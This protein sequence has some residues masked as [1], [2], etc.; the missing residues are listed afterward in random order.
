MLHNPTYGAEDCP[1][2]PRTRS[3]LDNV[4]PTDLYE[5]ISEVQQ[6]N[7]TDT[8]VTSCY[9][10]VVPELH[11]IPSE[12]EC[13]VEC[14]PTSST[15]V[16]PDPQAAQKSQK[17]EKS[18]AG[19]AVTAYAVSSIAVTNKKTSRSFSRDIDE[20]KAT[21]P[22]ENASRHF[23]EG[24][25]PLSQ[26]KRRKPKPAPMPKKLRELTVMKTKSFTQSN[27]GANNQQ[28]FSASTSVPESEKYSKLNP[29][30]QYM[31]LEPHIG[32]NGKRKK[33]LADVPA[34]KEKYSHLKH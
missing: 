14:T 8:P 18:K 23:S 21:G 2:S 24:K 13:T 16:T 32:S 20:S 15:T 6:D 7:K 4:G 10:Y 22:F 31:G 34:S 28:T 12:S 1:T 25:A 11:R 33:D 27:A 29:K 26:H 5:E 17:H 3:S 9:A 19:K 30:T